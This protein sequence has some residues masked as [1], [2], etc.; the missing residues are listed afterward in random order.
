MNTEKR[1]WF[2]FFNDQLLVEKRDGELTVPYQDTPPTPIP[3]WTHIHELSLF[4]GEMF[5]A[6]SLSAPIPEDEHFAMI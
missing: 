2:V 5:N 3:E 4:D 1:L 6:Y